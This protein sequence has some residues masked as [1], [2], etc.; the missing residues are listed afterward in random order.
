MIQEYS[1]DNGY[2]VIYTEDLSQREITAFLAVRPETHQDSLNTLLNEIAE[3]HN[4]QFVFRFSD[5]G[6]A[7]VVKSLDFPNVQNII[8][9]ITSQFSS[10]G[11][12]QS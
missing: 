9:D 4:H 6:I 1:V 11:Y 10:A 8:A 2:Y 3:K 5:N 7:I 12:H